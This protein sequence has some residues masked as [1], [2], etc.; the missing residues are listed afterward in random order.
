MGC[1]TLGSS[2]QGERKAINN[3]KKAAEKA[4]EWLWLK[5]GDHWDQ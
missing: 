3:N 4:S 1:I 2:G 5:R